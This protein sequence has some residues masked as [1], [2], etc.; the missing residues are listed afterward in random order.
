MKGGMSDRRDG[1]HNCQPTDRHA[2]T[3]MMCASAVCDIVC[4]VLA[5]RG[6]L[7]GSIVKTILKYR[8]NFRSNLQAYAF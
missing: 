1:H 6:D 4:V 8:I 3:L 7:N 5:D 2:H